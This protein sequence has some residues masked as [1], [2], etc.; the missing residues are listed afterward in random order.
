MPTIAYRATRSRRKF[1]KSQKVKRLL[2]DAL[3]NEVKPE[4][5][6]RFNRVTVNWKKKPDFKSRK[7]VRLTSV[8]VNVFPAGEHK[9]IWVWVSGGTKP[10]PI[11]ARRAPRLAFLWGGPGSYKPKTK[12]VGKFGGPGVVVGGTIHKPV[13]VDHPGTTAR[14][15]EKVIRDD[16]KTEFSRIMNNAFRRIIRRV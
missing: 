3:D 13:E 10:H 5:I 7:F 16:F 11:S 2:G 12:P 9:M 14:E 15:F 4:L 1:V 6:K 8:A